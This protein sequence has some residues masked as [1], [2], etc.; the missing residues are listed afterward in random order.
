LLSVIIV[1]ME[2]SRLSGELKYIEANGVT[3]NIEERTQL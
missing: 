3:L 1:K 2:L